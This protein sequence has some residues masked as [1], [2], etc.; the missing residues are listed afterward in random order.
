M[1]YSKSL[2]GVGWI[3]LV[4][5]GTYPDPIMLAEVD[6]FDI[7]VNEDER[8]YLVHLRLLQEWLVCAPGPGGGEKGDK[9]D[10][11]DQGDPGHDGDPGEKGD[12]GGPGE[13]LES[14]LTRIV[15]LSWP[16]GGSALLDVV[17]DGKD[18]KGL[19]IAFGKEALGDGGLARVESGS[20]D[21]ETFQIFVELP[22]TES[23]VDFWTYRRVRPDTILPVEAVADAGGFVTRAGQ[24]TGPE[25]PAAALLLSDSAY[26]FLEG[27][28]II[29]CVKGD[30]ILDE[31]GKRAIDAEYVRTE[32]PTGDRP[33]EAKV[34]VQGGRFESWLRVG[35]LI[36]VNTATVAEL[37]TL[38]RIGPAL[39]ARIVETR[40]AR[41]GFRSIDG[42]LAV[43]GVGPE[44]L[45]NIR[46]FITVGS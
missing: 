8:P 27:K 9:G 44:L 14:D 3:S 37:Q 22:M 12:P 11:G 15:A 29:V 31:T 16:H 39:A 35:R 40:T 26:K 17:V 18:L 33:R 10:K 30:Y 41:G 13:G 23:G 5:S 19:I 42:L 1:S 45:N 24:V 6:G 25:A 43:P 4:P 36:D 38:P 46:P 32:L 28:R 21:D 2:A 7:D 34:G 20:L